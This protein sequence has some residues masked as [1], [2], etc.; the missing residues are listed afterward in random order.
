M[1]KLTCALLLLLPL[2]AAAQTSKLL[3][4]GQVLDENSKPVAGAAVWAFPDF[5]SG[6]VPRAVTDNEG[7]FTIE[8]R[9]PGRYRLSADKV[10]SGYPSTINPFYYPR[11]AGTDQVV[12]KWEAPAPFITV[13]FAPPAGK[14][15]VQVSDQANAPV[16][17]VQIALCRADA[18]RHCYRQNLFARDGLFSVWT[19]S[20]RVLLDV[21]A[22]GY[23]DAYV[24]D[25]HENKPR[26]L[27]VPSNT[28]AQVNVSLKKKTAGGSSSSILKAPEQLS[29]ENGTELVHFPRTT[30]LTWLPVLGAASY[31]VE[32]D[33][34][35]GAGI[36]EN[37]KDPH[38]LHHMDLAPTSGIEGTN[39]KFSFLGAQPARWR[40]WAVDREGNAGLKSGWFVFFYRE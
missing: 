1:R 6:R 8:V 7:R 5:L 23:E 25:E 35:D 28:S 15:M 38:P 9:Q 13:R 3:I 19:S 37:C 20:D 21:Y 32:I 12:V 33:F 29:P 31:T 2:L 39:Y 14:L 30:E 10:R 22:E 34:C 24:V 36:P 27:S 18:P 11:T 26:F 17:K 4:T 40:V 16:Q